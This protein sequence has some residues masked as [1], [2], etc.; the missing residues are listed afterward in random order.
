MA[1]K[2]PL[3]AFTT[4]SDRIFLYKPLESNDSKTPSDTHKSSIPD[5]VVV[6]AWAFAQPRRKSPSTNAG[7]PVSD[8]MS[9]AA[10][11]PNRK[12]QNI[13]PYDEDS[14]FVYRASFMRNFSP[15]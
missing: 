1:Q 4:L 7:L 15:C 3:S 9:V 14:D 5:F 2:D 13:A 12:T 10:L 6:C 11:W 8:V